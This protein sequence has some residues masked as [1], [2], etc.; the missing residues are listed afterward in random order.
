MSE[1]L[2]WSF[3]L[4]LCLSQVKDWSRNS[5]IIWNFLHS[6]VSVIT[7]DWCRYKKWAG[8]RSLQKKKIPMR[9][10]RRSWMGSMYIS[11][12]KC[13]SAGVK[14]VQMRVGRYKKCACATHVQ[15]H[16][17]RFKEKWQ[18]VCTVQCSGAK[19]KYMQRHV[20]RCRCNCKKCASARRAQV[21][22]C[23]LPYDIIQI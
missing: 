23:T 14:R 12:W 9:V 10:C 18:F 6:T 22:L 21:R 2:T 4:Y 8:A 5:R 7:M 16:V 19:K 13:K 1:T 3:F 11:V 17:C 15:M 20:L